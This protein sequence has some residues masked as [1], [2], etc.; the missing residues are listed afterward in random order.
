MKEESDDCDIQVT[1]QQWVTTDR[2]DLINQTLHI[3]DFINF[4]CENLDAIT[5][6]SYIAQHQSQYLKNLKEDLQPNEVIVLEDFTENYNFLMQD[7]VQ[8]YHWN[9]QQC[10]LHP[11]VIYYKSDG[12]LA[13]VSLCIIS[14][15]LTHDVSFVYRSCLKQLTL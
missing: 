7:E 4:L 2:S 14:N 5:T 13:E 9:S 1:F 8:G 12:K 3:E 10:T 15:Y 11:V 6:H